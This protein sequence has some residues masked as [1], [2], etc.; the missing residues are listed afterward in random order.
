MPGCL[1]TVIEG[2]QNMVVM[3]VADGCCFAL[4]TFDIV[5]VAAGHDLDGYIAMHEFV[6]GQINFRHAAMAKAALQAIAA[7]LVPSNPCINSY[8]PRMMNIRLFAIGDL[9]QV[10]LAVYSS[11]VLNVNSY[12]CSSSFVT[13][14]DCSQP[15]AA[16]P[17]RE[18][19][20]A[21]RPAAAQPTPTP[22]LANCRRQ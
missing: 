7:N 10:V 20:W 3:Q 17:G 21:V 16:H 22:Y 18:W 11:L 9:M 5:R 4:E 6:I 2:G 19:V 15:A 1:F 13:I 12:S 14:Q 8:I